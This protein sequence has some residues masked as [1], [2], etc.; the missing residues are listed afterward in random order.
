WREIAGNMATNK[1]TDPEVFRM[2]KEH[3]LTKAYLEYLSQRRVNLM[4]A[5]GS[6]RLLQPEDQMEAFLCQQMV[7][8]DCNA[9][10]GVFDLE[11]IEEDDAE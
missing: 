6:G 5:W 10:R 8:L 7:E 3:R 1:L 2:W 4:E 9:V 11:P